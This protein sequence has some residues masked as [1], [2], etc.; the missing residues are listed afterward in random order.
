MKKQ[1][2]A[3]IAISILAVCSAFVWVAQTPRGWQV[4][5]RAVSRRPSHLPSAATS[6]QLL[7]SPSPV[8]L[9]SLEAVADVHRE[10]DILSL[11]SRRVSL[12]GPL[13]VTFEPVASL[14]LTMPLA[15]ASHAAPDMES[16]TDE[17]A[18][19]EVETPWPLA[20]S[21]LIQ[22]DELASLEFCSNWAEQ[23]RYEVRCLATLE[24]LHCPQAAKTLDVLDALA[25]ETEK[26]AASAPSPEEQRRARAAGYA[27][28]R[29]LAVWRSVYELAG[30]PD[31]FTV[32][33]ALH[34]E[35]MLERLTSVD[36]ALGHGRGASD[37]RRWLLTGQTRLLAE[38][39]T[40][41][42]PHGRRRHAQHVLR[43]MEWSG[44][45]DPQ[46]QFLAREEFIALAGELRG[47]AAAPFDF[48]RLME[49][50]EEYEQQPTADAGRRIADYSRRLTWAGHASAAELAARLETHYRN[51][52]VRTAVS[53]DLL[54][55]FAPTRQTTTDRV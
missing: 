43:R 2:S 25:A 6:P 45:S 16:L 28:A 10:T 49:T 37:W 22:L 8:M 51:A 4:D 27:L 13:D 48:A 9:A 23:G 15:P 7:S 11:A 47:W 21:L 33:V 42:D 31:E 44:L 40:G 39:G 46:R 54:Q 52:N 32:E 36:A 26:T 30:Q 24:E 3:V 41:G 34:P 12:E 55:R 18:A 38:A 35:R 50:I 1:R 20:K 17:A 53:Q 5:E 29:R 19:G 14:D